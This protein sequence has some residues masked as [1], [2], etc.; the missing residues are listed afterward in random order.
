[1]NSGEG[2]SSNKSFLGQ[3]FRGHIFEQAKTFFGGTTILT[4]GFYVISCLQLG[5]VYKARVIV[6]LHESKF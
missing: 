2:I 1:M 6:Q 3:P 5:G 4:K